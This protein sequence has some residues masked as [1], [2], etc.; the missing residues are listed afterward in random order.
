MD[1]KSVFPCKPGVDSSN[2]TLTNTSTPTCCNLSLDSTVES[3]GVGSVPTVQYWLLVVML[4]V[5]LVWYAFLRRKQNSTAANANLANV[6]PAD[7]TVHVKGLGLGASHR[8]DRS[9]L[10]NNFA[11]RYGDVASAVFTT[12]VGTYLRDEYELKRL[13][14][15]EA[16]LE[17]L[18][19]DT[20]ASKQPTLSCRACIFVTKSSKKSDQKCFRC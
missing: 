18:T 2:Y 8:E 14:E 13:T 11:S 10:T 9:Y 20:Q 19:S 12:N 16:E 3:A 15:L 4:A 1:C 7:F 5:I 17:R 6:T